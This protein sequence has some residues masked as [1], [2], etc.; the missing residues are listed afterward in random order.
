MSVV[1]ELREIQSE[2][3]KLRKQIEKLE[4]AFEETLYLAYHF[5]IGPFIHN[6]TDNFIIIEKGGYYAVYADTKE[7]LESLCKKIKKDNLEIFEPY[8]RG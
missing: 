2:I 8:G 7:E 3:D 1:Q 5:R 4:I 6:I